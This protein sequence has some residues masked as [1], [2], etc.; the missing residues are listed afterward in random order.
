MTSAVLCMICSSAPMKYT[1]SRCN[2][3]YCSLPCYKNHREC[4]E[5]FYKTQVRQEMA[6][7]K[8]DSS[9]RAKMLDILQKVR[10][11][12]LTNPP[13]LLHQ[14]HS[15]LSPGPLQPHPC[16]LDQSPPLT[17]RFDTLDIAADP[18]GALDLESLCQ[19][20]TTLGHRVM[21]VYTPIVSILPVFRRTCPHS[22]ATRGLSRRARAR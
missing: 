15:H 18:P 4:S 8:I 20:E 1:C 6:G 19:D 16:R 22:R 10:E 21:C 2:A 3:P 17:Q 7:M 14:S 11:S 9:E 12:P 13:A 5:E